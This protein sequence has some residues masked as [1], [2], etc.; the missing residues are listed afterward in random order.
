MELERSVGVVSTVVG[1]DIQERPHKVEALSGH[2]GDQKNGA[3]PLAD[4]LCSGVNALLAVANKGWYLSGAWTFHDLG[5]LSDGFLEDIGGA[6]I[7]LG[8]HHHDGDV[9]C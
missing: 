8:H 6:D 5:D 3:Y 2:V 4:E 1:E 9:E 7:N